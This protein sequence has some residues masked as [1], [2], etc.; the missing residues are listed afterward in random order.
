MAEEDARSLTEAGEDHHFDIL[1]VLPALQV[2]DE[3]AKRVGFGSHRRLLCRHGRHSFFSDDE[4]G[5]DA[6]GG[7][8][9]D[10]H[11]VNMSSWCEYEDHE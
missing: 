7:S 8:R 6:S 2:R 4:K 9:E 11:S 3:L 10:F 1:H 5:R